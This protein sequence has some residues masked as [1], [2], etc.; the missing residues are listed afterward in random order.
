MRRS[1]LE[2]LG[3]AAPHGPI[4]CAYV[5]DLG[6]KDALLASDPAAFFTTPHFKAFPAVL[7]RLAEIAVPDL[8]ELLV[9]AWLC[10]AP[11]RL[12]ATY[13]AGQAERPS[14]RGGV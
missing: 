6:A 10:R 9:E 2:A 1:D 14:R 4:L 13:L 11:K 8:E 7:V 12:A 3:A 5:P